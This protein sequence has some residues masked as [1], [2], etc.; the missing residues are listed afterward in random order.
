[1]AEINTDLIH[2]AQEGDLATIAGLY[3]RFHLKIFRYIYYRVGDAQ[4]AEDLTSEVFLRMLR[5]LGNFKKTSTPFQ[6]WLFQI[7]R[8]LSIDHY[9]K[10]RAHQ[11]EALV[12]NLNGSVDDTARSLDQILTS[13]HLRRALDQL[14]EDQRDVIVLRFVAEMPIAEVAQVLNKSENAV[15]GLQRRGLIALREILDEQE[16]SYA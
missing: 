9:R 11:V 16:V 1:M 8:N 12:E 2:R 13:E 5:Y 7:A 4:T 14:T 3:E 10:S 15:K 6:A